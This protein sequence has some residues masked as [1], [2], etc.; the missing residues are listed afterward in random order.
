M[1]SCYIVDVN[2]CED[3]T[4]CPGA[5]EWCVNLPGGF[6]CCN[7]DSKDPECFGSD[8]KLDGNNFIFIFVVIII[9]LP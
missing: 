1:K 6:I 7:A 9:Y 8:S 2:E 3:D 4:Q 5:G